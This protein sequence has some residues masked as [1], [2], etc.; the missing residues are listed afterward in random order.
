MTP[1]VQ[2]GG[3]NLSAAGRFFFALRHGEWID[4]LSDCVY[5]R[6]H[7]SFAS[8]RFQHCLCAF[9]GHRFSVCNVIENVSGSIV[10]G[11]LVAIFAFRTGIP[12][13]WQLF[14]TTGILGGYTTFSTFSLV[15]ALLYEWPDRPR[16]TLRPA[17]GRAFDRWAV[18]EARAGPQSGLS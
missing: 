13:H 2:Q 9:A 17:V 12:H 8:A 6:R 15:V 11:I 1:T 7:W 4:G 14:L 5:R 18:R 10:M 3:R 16:G